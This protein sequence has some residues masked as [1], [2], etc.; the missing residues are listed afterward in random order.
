MR[1][2]KIAAST[3]HNLSSKVPGKKR[4]KHCKNCSC[5]LAT[6]SALVHHLKEAHN[7]HVEVSELAAVCKDCQQSEQN[8]ESLKALEKHLRKKHFIDIHS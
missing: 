7:I 2:L 5:D 6:D 4:M 8:H 3:V 1:T